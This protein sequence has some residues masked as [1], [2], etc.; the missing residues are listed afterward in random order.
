MRVIAGSLR[1]GLRL[2]LRLLLRL[3]LSAAGERQRENARDYDA[4]GGS[5]PAPNPA[6]AQRAVNRF[7]NLASIERDRYAPSM[8]GIIIA[9]CGTLALLAATAS[10]QDRNDLKDLR[11][12]GLIVGGM[13]QDAQRCGFTRSLIRDAIA[14]P[15][16]SSK[17]DF[18]GDY[19]GGAALNVRV[20]AMVQTQPLECI[21]EVD[22]DVFSIQQVQLDYSNQ[23]ARFFPV[24]L[25]HDSWLSASPPEQHAQQIRTAIENAAKKLVTDWNLANKP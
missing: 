11:S 10:A 20:T 13:D 17:L 7:G 6:L 5:P 3:I 2:C 15:I 1:L 21:S 16:S 25:W 4:H 23:P 22:V 19:K 24:E 9:A 12:V 18:S 8:R 14:Y